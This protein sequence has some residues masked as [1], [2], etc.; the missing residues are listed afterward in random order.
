MR[1]FLM[2]LCSASGGRQIYFQLN[3]MQELTTVLDMRHFQY[4]CKL[5][6][7]KRANICA[8]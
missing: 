2:T 1:K 7:K 4:K 6:E 8:D 3:G 5:Q